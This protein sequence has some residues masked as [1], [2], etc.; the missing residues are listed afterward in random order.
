M[1]F[2][3]LSGQLR[4]GLDEFTGVRTAPTIQASVIRHSR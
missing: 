4:A 2:D 1:G 3:D